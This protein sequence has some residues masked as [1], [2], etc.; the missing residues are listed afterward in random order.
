[1]V[2][3]DAQKQV[4]KHSQATSIEIAMPA[5]PMVVAEGAFHDAEHVPAHV[6]Q[7]AARV[8]GTG[9]RLGVLIAIDL[10][11]FLRR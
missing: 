3:Q 2:E 5:E 10:A 6:D 9:G 4:R 1:M 8:V 7:R 11:S